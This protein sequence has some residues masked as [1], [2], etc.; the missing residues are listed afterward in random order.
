M[1]LTLEISEKVKR[2]DEHSQKLVLGVVSRFL[3]ENEDD[4]LTNED[5]IDIDVA[6]KERVNGEVYSFSDI[7]NNLI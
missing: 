5:L 6:R 3:N 1:D 4:F 2:L 7:E